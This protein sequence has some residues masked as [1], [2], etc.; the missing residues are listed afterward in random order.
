MV[1]DGRISQT[2]TEAVLEVAVG[3]VGTAVGAD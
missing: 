3:G 2:R 1:W